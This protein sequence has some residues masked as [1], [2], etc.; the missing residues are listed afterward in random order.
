MTRFEIAS[1]FWLLLLFALV[2]VLLLRIRAHLL[3]RRGAPGLV[4]PQLRRQLITGSSIVWRWLRFSLF[5]LAFAAVTVALARPRWGVEKVETQSHGRNILIAIDTSRSMLANDVSPSRLDRAKL[6][7]E[8]IVK[9]LPGD[10]IGLV[11]FAGGAFVQAP[12]TVDHAAVVETLRQVDTELI[13]RGGTNLG[14]AVQ[15][16]IETVQKAD[17]GESALI[18]FSDGE[19]LEG[20]EQLADLRQQAAASGMTIVAIAVGTEAGSIIPDP[21]ANEPGVFV[22]DESGQIVRSRLNPLALQAISAD[23]ENGLYLALDSRRSISSV[24][25]ASLSQLELTSGEEVERERPI[26]RFGWFLAIG[27]LLFAAGWVLP[28]F[29][30]S[31]KAISSVKASQQKPTPVYRSATPRSALAPSG[32]A[33][34][35]TASAAAGAPPSVEEIERLKSRDGTASLLVVAALSLASF[36]TF[37]APALGQGSGTDTPRSDDS[38]ATP[39]AAPDELRA[40]EIAAEEALEAMQDGRYERA[41]SAY[42][43]AIGSGAENADGISR[44]DPELNFG[45]GSAA[46]KLGDYETA[47][48]A[49]SRALESADR[50]LATRAQYNLANTL[51]RHGETFLDESLAR[52][53]KTAAAEQWTSALEHYQGALK[54][55]PRNNRARHNADV[56]SARLELLKQEQ[57]EEEQ[58][59][60]EDEKSEEEKDDKEDPPKED[61]E[62]EEEKEDEDKNKDDEED[63]EKDENGEGDGQN[64]NQNQ[65]KDD[66]QNE[67]NSDDGGS[68]GNQDQNQNPDK[69]ED[70][71]GDQ[72]SNSDSEGG[73]QPPPDG[74]GD[75]GSDGNEGQQPPPEGGSDP[76]NEQKGDEDDGKSPPPSGADGSQPPP[77]KPENSD[78]DQKDGE[79]SNGPERRPEPQDSS[80]APNSESEEPPEGKL[81]A[82][83]PQQSENGQPAQPQNANPGN[84]QAG[85]AS[86]QDGERDPNADVMNAETGYTP[87]EARRLLRTQSEEALRMLRVRA[88]QS[89]DRYRNW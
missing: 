62:E 13:P 59:Q 48:Q 7:A 32:A 44:P 16:A 47:K 74:G 55:D 9:S 67:N 76:S 36:S 41:A 22:K 6:A 69:N 85:N 8:D 17:V 25:A 27:L 43:A 61:E 45:L 2:P 18:L 20:G 15:I 5:A 28:D 81:E 14:S 39:A 79:G 75:Q 33:S 77:A 31:H 78:A 11:A 19:D 46:Y 84:A 58:Q 83:P 21:E 1:P 42:R 3:A 30:R 70:Q 29:R 24:V 64:Q 63:K 50:E 71:G 23:T 66:K 52:P 73:Q 26:E 12:L 54:L 65:D 80:A 35:G 49:F 60:K 4:S 37:T 87:S 34:G 51:F 53:D 89:N 40:P 88:P 57:A 10:R 38:P 72:N 68:D 56:V 82:N 86:Q